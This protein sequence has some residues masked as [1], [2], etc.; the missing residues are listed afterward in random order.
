MDVADA[1]RVFAVLLAIGVWWL[2]PRGSL[3][4]GG[5]VVSATRLSASARRDSFVRH[6]L[7]HA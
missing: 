4:N 7:S 6:E 5:R 3:G 1:A 2:L